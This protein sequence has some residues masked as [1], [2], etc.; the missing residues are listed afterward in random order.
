MVAVTAVL[1][2][3]I[4]RRIRKQVTKLSRCMKTDGS[5]GNKNGHIKCSSSRYSEEY[6]EDNTYHE[7]RDYKFFC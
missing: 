4:K 1:H 3:K 6:M 7:L 5:I 2:V